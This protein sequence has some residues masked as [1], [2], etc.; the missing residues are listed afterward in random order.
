M[1]WSVGNVGKVLERFGMQ[2]AKNVMTSVDMSTNLTKDV[3]D[4]E[5]FD[6]RVYEIC[7][8]ELA[9]FVNVHEARFAST[10]RFSANPTKCCWI[11]I[12]RIS[13]VNPI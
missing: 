2:E 8:W 4:D 13:R 1:D 6:R 3:E 12:K 7:C 9:V 11:G 10:V 5:S